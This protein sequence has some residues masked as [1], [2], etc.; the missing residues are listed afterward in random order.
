MPIQIVFRLILSCCLGLYAA[1]GL[2]APGRVPAQTGFF[3][4]GANQSEVCRGDGRDI[5]PAVSYQPL[6]RP[7]AS[8]PSVESG[9]EFWNGM[10]L[11]LI[12]KYQRNPLRAARIMTLLN[13][14]VHD[15]MACVGDDRQQAEARVIAVNEVAAEILGFMFPQEPEGRFVALALGRMP[16]LASEKKSG[17]VQTA[18]EIGR[19]VAQTAIVRAINDGS[20]AVWSVETRPASAPGIWRATPPTY[21]N[22]PAEPLAGKWRTWVLRDGA[23]LQPPSPPP[24]GTDQYRQEMEEVRA[25]T[26]GLTKAQKDIADRW[27]L[28]SGTVTPVGVWNREALRLIRLHGYTEFQ[29]AELLSSLNVA[30]MDASIACWYAKFAN[31]TA[32]PVTVIREQIDKEFMPY[33]VTPSFPS[34]VS[35]HSV[36][37]GAAAE[38]LASYFPKRRAELFAMAEEAAVSRLYGGIHFRSDNVEGLKLGHAVGVRVLR[39]AATDAGKKRVPEAQRGRT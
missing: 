30:M 35:G 12:V 32:R 37:S 4:L 6:S 29:A 1:Q 2:T 14:A 19:K 20:D 5:Y 10:A 26:M 9:V 39:K 21:N 15:A 22:T 28:G 8:Q 3:W 33:L 17:A 7:L 13:A 27:H 18:R 34:Y 31:W 11:D 23:E 38:V 36:V 16:T 25:V 24:Y